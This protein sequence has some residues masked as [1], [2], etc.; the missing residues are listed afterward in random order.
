MQDREGGSLL[1]ERQGYTDLLLGTIAMM[2]GRGL[3]S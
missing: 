2:E 3:G 1:V